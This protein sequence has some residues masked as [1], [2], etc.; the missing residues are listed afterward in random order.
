MAKPNPEARVYAAIDDLQ[1]D[2]EKPTVA[3]VR[4]RAGVN[5]ADATRY[6]R[7]WREGKASSGATIAALPASLVEQS[8]RVVGLMWAEA[9]ATAAASH[10]A[11]EQEWR[12]GLAAAEQAARAAAATHAAER[13]A[14]EEE[15]ETARA[16]E[17]RATTERQALEQAQ[18][19]L[20]TRLVEERATNQTL[21]ETVAAFI[22]R[23]PAAE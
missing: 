1:R 16:N 15:L 3:N 8:Q 12:E 22:G 7:E 4:S 18:A 2:G 9:V 21:R 23:F 14:L 17:A 6:L 19:D 5:N 13:A 11:L 20:E 10:A